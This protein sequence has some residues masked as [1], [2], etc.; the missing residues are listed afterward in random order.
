MAFAG[1]E[2]S[3]NHIKEGK[4]LEAFIHRYYFIFDVETQLAEPLDP[5]NPDIRIQL[6]TWGPKSNYVAFTRENNMFLRVLSSTAVRQITKDGGPEYFYGIPDWVYEEEVFASNTATW[7]DNE[8]QYIAFMRT[9]ETMVP[10]YPVQY[11]LSRPSGKKPIAGEEAYPE[12]RKIN[13][14]KRAHRTQLWISCSMT[15][16]ETKCSQS[17]RMRPSQMTIESSM[18]CSGPRMGKPCVVYQTVRA[19]SSN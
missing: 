16:L 5:E 1:S 4:E 18:K 2:E 19:T 8:G 15:Y 13:I 14:Q 12:V 9:N 17:M 10:T 11:F 3:I 6:A 7:W